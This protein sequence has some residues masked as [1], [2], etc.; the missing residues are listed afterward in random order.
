VRRILRIASTLMI[1]AGLCLLLWALVVWRWQDPFTALY[2]AYQQHRLETRYDTRLATYQ[3]LPT[4]TRPTSNPRVSR[5]A[6]QHMVA[7]EAS[8]YRRSLEIGD[9]VGRLKVPRLGLDLIVVNGTD[10]DSLTRGPGR[11]L[12]SFVPGEGRLIYI[13]GHRTTYGAPFAHIERLRPGDAV[14]F[15]VPYGRFVYRVTSSVIVPADEVSRLES[16]GLE[17]VAL[18]ACHPR[19][20]ASHRYIAYARPVRVVPRDGAPYSPRARVAG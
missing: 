9:P 18:Q 11:Y 20:F 10:H 16:R 6:E 17:E 5:A 8:R 14:S 3:P 1:A 4:P 13:A 12:G 15:E 2:T 7:R 19:F